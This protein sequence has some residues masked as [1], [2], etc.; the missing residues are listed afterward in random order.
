MSTPRPAAW[1]A[2]QARWS[3]LAAREQNLLL[4][5]C[6]VLALALL[7]WLALAPAL[8]TLR[9]APARHAELDS[10]LQQMLA[11]QQEAQQLQNAPQLR[12]ADARRSL[13]NALAQQLGESAKIQFS[14]DRAT[15]TIKDANASALAQW[16]VL[17]RNNA[18]AA[19]QEAHLARAG[20]AP[21]QRTSTAEEPRW[22]GSLVLTLP[23]ADKAR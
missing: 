4:G 19:T 11:L 22:S 14:G 13:Q 6:A 7:W 18:H 3:K 12:T 23:S 1:L 5:A 9:S 2:L 17:A 8:A 15:V 21:T 16:L 20:D 10:A